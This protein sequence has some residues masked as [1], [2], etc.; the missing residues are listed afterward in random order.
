MD[1]LHVDG[2]QLLLAVIW[3]L[4]QEWMKS[5]QWPLF[6]WLTKESG[7]LNRALSP[8]VA[9]LAT[10]GLHFTITGNASSGWHFEGMIPPLTVMGHIAGQWVLQH[11]LYHVGIKGP[12]VNQA[13][14]DVNEQIL[15]E[16]KQQRPKEMHLTVDAASAP[17]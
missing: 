4:L 2:W 10:L 6:G 12:K 13:L 1:D 16:M 3:P 15:D 11:F 14:L 5:T 8:A 9:I 17:R 7:F